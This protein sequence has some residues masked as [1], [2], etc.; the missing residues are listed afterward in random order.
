M[1]CQCLNKNKE[2]EINAELKD[3]L[4]KTE[5]E[6]INVFN[7][8]E[9]ENLMEI[10]KKETQD[11]ITD[12]DS[13]I[14]NTKEETVNR[15]NFRVLELINKIRKN[16]PSYANTVLENIKNITVE[17][18]KTVF[19]KKVKVLLNKGESEFKNAADILKKTNPMNEL[20]SKKEI[21]IPLPLSYEEIH[22]NL[23]LINQVNI[24]RQNFNVNVYFKNLIKNPEIAVLMLI[25]DDSVDNPGMRRNAILNPKFRKI[26]INS[27]FIGNTF[28]SFFSFSK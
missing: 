18:N 14:D 10:K 15:F 3:D 24:I 6:I 19:R 7:K 28:V 9:C 27:K 16:P 26:G 21:E 22:D 4:N 23:L 13:Q 2:E 20:V 5:P 25:V 1:G 8:E 17:G 11:K 12:L